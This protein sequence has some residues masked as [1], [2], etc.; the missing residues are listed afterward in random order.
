MGTLKGLVVFG[1]N[2]S[3]LGATGLVHK[4]IDKSLQYTTRDFILMTADFEQNLRAES[5]MKKVYYIIWK[6]LAI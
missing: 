5:F 1:K 6:G 3:A 4:K 2:F